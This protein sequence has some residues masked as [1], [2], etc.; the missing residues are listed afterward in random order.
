MLVALSVLAGPAA[1]PVSLTEAKSALRVDHNLDDSLISSLIVSARLWVEGYTLRAVSTQTLRAVWEGELASPLAIP[2]PP[3]V[4]VVGAAYR[5]DYDSSEVTFTP[6]I[7]S[8][9]EPARLRIDTLPTL[10]DGGYLR[11]DYTAGYATPPEAMRTA[12][13]LGVQAAY[14]QGLYD[15]PESARALLQP[16]RVVFDA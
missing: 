9:A 3:F 7:V 14:D 1:E 8:S 15:L 11:L 2:R 13:L 4:S 16:Y 5:V 10:G 6:D 12:I